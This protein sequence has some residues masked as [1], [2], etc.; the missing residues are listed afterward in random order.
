MAALGDGTGLLW[1]SRVWPHL[2]NTRDEGVGVRPGLGPGREKMEGTGQQWLCGLKGQ[3]R[4]GWG[5]G[6]R[7]GREGALKQDSLKAT[8]GL[9]PRTELVAHRPFAFRPRR[10]FSPSSPP[11]ANS[12]EGAGR[13]RGALLAAAASQLPTRR[14]GLSATDNRKRLSRRLT[15]SRRLDA[16]SRP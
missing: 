3:V 16:R 10:P 11:T 4:V 1:G 12:P 6:L 5:A 7:P 15:Q 8:R 2:R 13:W 14:C 9:G